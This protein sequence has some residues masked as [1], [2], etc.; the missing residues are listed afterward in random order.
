MTYW[1]ALDTDNDSTTGGIPADVVS[2][3]SINGVDA[4]AQIEIERLGHSRDQ[5]AELGP[6]LL[7]FPT[8]WVWDSGTA[9][10]EAAA[11]DPGELVAQ[12]KNIE[13]GIDLLPGA[14]GPS[15]IPLFA[16]VSVFVAQNL[17]PTSGPVGRLFEYGLGLQATAA[18]A[19]GAQELDVGP[20]SRRYWFS[21]ES[22]FRRSS[23]QR[24]RRA[25][26]W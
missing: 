2:G 17:L 14:D 7:A 26:K 8:L 10:F 9:A 22:S 15:S 21:R 5:S 19:D 6:Y 23:L 4:I 18:N 12:A 1:I 13:L 16:E 20:M 11:P 24:R 3:L 25:A